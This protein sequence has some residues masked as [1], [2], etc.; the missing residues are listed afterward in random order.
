MTSG[1]LTV[2]GKTGIISTSGGDVSGPASSTANAVVRFSGTTGK[3][4]LNT[5]TLTL[6]D[7]GA[8]SFADGVRQTFNPSNTV[9]GFNPGSN[10]SDPSSATNGDMYYNT[11]SNKFRCYQAS[12]WSDCVTAAAAVTSVFGRTGVVV[13]TTN[14]YTF[15][16]IGSTPTTVAGYGITNAALNGSIAASGL[17][18]TGPTLLG[19]AASGTGAIETITVGAGLNLSIAGLLTV[20][21]G[22]IGG[23]NTQLQY[24]NN[25][26]FGGISGA[27]TNG[28][29]VTFASGALIASDITNSGTLTL[30]TATTTLVG[31]GTSDTL[32]NKTLTASTNVLGGVTMTLGSDAN[33]DTY[34][35]ASSVLTRL[36][37]G[38]N[39]QCLTSNGTIPVWGSCGSSTPGGSTT[40]LQ[41]NNAGAFGGI[42]GAT[43]NGTAVTFASAALLGSDITLT[44]NALLNTSS[45][46]TGIGVAAS[47]SEQL[48]V[49]SLATTRV[50]ESINSAANSS[51]DLVTWNQ[52]VDDTSTVANLNTVDVRSNGTAAA[53]F[54]TS[55]TIALESNTTNSRTAG[56]D[57]IY[58]RTATD[59]Q[60]SSVRSW[61]SVS[62]ATTSQD[63]LVIA[64]DVTLTDN[65]ATTVFSL[66]VPS[67]TTTGGSAQ[68]TVTASDGADYNVSS[69]VI[70]YSGANKA[71]TLN[72][73]ANLIGSAI[74]YNSA[75]SFTALTVAASAA[76]TTLSIQ[77]NANSSLTDPG[78]TGRCV[79]ENNSNSVVTIP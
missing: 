55:T 37:I 36:A 68:C 67:G 2:D 57:R 29:A 46:T 63:R 7:A 49:T 60:R 33:G 30:P 13:A 18:T 44:T 48:N 45:G 1:S 75:G 12:S 42:S 39:G 3:V 15:A 34:Y 6:S 58:W 16:Q 65:A 11:G 47:P 24:N 59:A 27:T 23:S 8:F 10:A 14:D 40:Q 4:L 76:G 54:G 31:T 25:G 62:G 71:G 50:A 51:V 70:G 79:I 35:R 9:T 53:G 38:S 56:T 69:F 74:T 26:G 17:T 66:A 77:I 52:N 64:P 72:G 21:G 28:T 43:T 61:G 41:Y 22:P 5:A 19:K 78:I 73:A 32:T 20:N